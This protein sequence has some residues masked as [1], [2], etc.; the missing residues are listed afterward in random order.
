MIRNETKPW[1]IRA[2]VRGGS[3]CVLQRRAMGIE[4]TV[5]EKKTNEK[6]DI[7]AIAHSKDYWGVGCCVFFVFLVMQVDVQSIKWIKRRGMYKGLSAGP[8]AATQ[9]QPMKQLCNVSRS[10]SFFLSREDQIICT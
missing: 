9:Q 6:C 5:G 7:T 4:K 8:P 10:F 3:R 2:G 1:E